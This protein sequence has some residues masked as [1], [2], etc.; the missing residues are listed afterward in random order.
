[1]QTLVD[2]IRST[3][4]TN[5]ILIDGLNWSEDLTQLLQYLPSD[6]Q[7]QL[8]ADYHNYISATSRNGLGYWNST[9]APVA[10]HMPLMTSE[11]GEK[12]C[13]SNYVTQYMQWADQYDISYIAWVWMNW[14]C[15]GLGLVADW[16]GTPSA[17]GQPFYVH[18]HSLSFTTN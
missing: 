3:G 5:P 2:A 7:H 6:P 16:N 11:F 8:I 13:H 14:P 1:M 4:A 17:Y 18:Y 12:D 10:A 15:S 9:I